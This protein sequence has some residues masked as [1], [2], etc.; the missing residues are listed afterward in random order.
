VTP[1]WD[2]RELWLPVTLREVRIMDLDKGCESAKSMYHHTKVPFKCWGKFTCRR[3]PCLS[4]P[5]LLGID[6]F[7][8]RDELYISGKIHNLYDNVIPGY[9]VCCIQQKVRFLG[10]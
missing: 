10:C 3:G 4:F 8:K 5:G 6:S 1:P 7:Q 9:A 2:P